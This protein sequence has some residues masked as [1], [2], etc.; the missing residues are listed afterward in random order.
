MFLLQTFLGQNP[1]AHKWTLFYIS[2]SFTKRSYQ[3]TAHPFHQVFSGCPVLSPMINAIS[4]R[5]LFNH[6]SNTVTWGFV[7]HSTA[8]P[9]L[10]LMMQNC[11]WRKK[12][13]SWFGAKVEMKLAIP[14]LPLQIPNLWDPTSQS[15]QGWGRMQMV[16]TKNLR[17]QCYI[18]MESL[19]A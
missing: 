10:Q 16:K 4:H 14:S 7:L 18:K 13:S 3:L 19:L 5:V 15:E 1:P 6:H 2:Q 17:F 9:P 11:S 12:C 8:L